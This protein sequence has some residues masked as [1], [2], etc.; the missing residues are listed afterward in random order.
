MFYKEDESVA[1]TNVIHICAIS[2]KL[3]IKVRKLQQIST[4]CKS[5]FLCMFANVIATLTHF[6][7][8]HNTDWEFHLGNNNN[9]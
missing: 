6:H 4:A 1:R 8:K 3:S 7:N 2:K 5:L 9:K